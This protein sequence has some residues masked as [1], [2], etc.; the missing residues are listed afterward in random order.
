MMKFTNFIGLLT[1]SLILSAPIFADHSPNKLMRN[2]IAYSQLGNTGKLGTFYVNFAE[3]GTI[4][5]QVKTT[6]ENKKFDRIFK[7]KFN[8]ATIVIKDNKIVYERYNSKRK[9]DS[10]TP[11]LG[12]SM[13]KTAASA[14]IGVLLCENKIKSLN[15]TAGIYSRTLNDSPYANIKIRNILHMNSGVSPLGRYDEKKFNHKSLGLTNKFSGKAS[16]REALS[17]YKKAARKQA[18]KFNY[19]SSDTLALSILIEEI[20]KMPLA[21]VFH[22][23]LYTKFGSSGYMHWSADKN[24]TTAPFTGLTMTAQDWAKFGKFIMTEKKASSCL[25]SFFNEGV[26]NAVK[27]GMKNGSRYGYQSWVFDVNNRPTL[28]L[29]GHGGQFLVLDEITDTVLLVI[30]INEKYISGN[31]FNN[32]HKFTEKLN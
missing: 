4:P 5:K 8:L 14:S 30:S 18:S 28:V 16:V 15:D 22:D 21:K 9:V 19:H 11:F 13:S 26:A 2:M 25:G 27:T 1:L 31:L 6:V 23:N 24:G 20:A 12:M 7:D 17:F 3:F 29:Q 32:I 10:N